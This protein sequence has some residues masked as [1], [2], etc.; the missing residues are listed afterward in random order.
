MKNMIPE[1]SYPFVYLDSSFIYR[2]NSNAMQK[3][4]RTFL[5]RHP[6]EFYNLLEE[7]ALAAE[8]DAPYYKR[9]VCLQNRNIIS[10][11]ITFESLNKELMTCSPH[12]IPLFGR[13][14]GEEE[15]GVAV[16]GDDI[17]LW[18]EKVRLNVYMKAA[19]EI[20]KSPC[21]VMD[22]TFLTLS[23][24]RSLTKYIT[25]NCI[26]CI[27]KSGMQQLSY[28]G[29]HILSELS[30]DQFIQRLCSLP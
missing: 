24:G 26:L 7:L 21:V 17:V 14:D 5:D 9:I 1:L 6:H 25:S 4:T 2:S 16:S 18:G 13:I 10:T 23:V 12:I 27:L 8:A 30:P 29:K 15:G 3:L 20:L 22:N 19:M 28:E 11:L